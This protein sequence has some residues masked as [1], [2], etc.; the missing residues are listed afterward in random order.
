MRR[1]LSDLL[2][3]CYCIAAVALIG[4]MG[5]ALGESVCVPLVP[6]EGESLYGKYL[7][8]SDAHFRLLDGYGIW[9]IDDSP[10][11]LFQIVGYSK[12]EKSDIYDTV[13][14]VTN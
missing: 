8:N 11:N 2:F 10:E 3:G 14:C 9:Y 5:Y 6:A 13:R 12:T 7:E 1:L 4:L